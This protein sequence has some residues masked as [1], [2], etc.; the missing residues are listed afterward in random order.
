MPHPPG[1]ITYV[2]SGG[3]CFPRA[4]VTKLKVHTNHVNVPSYSDGLITWIHSPPDAVIGYTKLRD[5]FVQWRSW[6][7]TLD[8]VV[9]WWYYQILPDPHE[10]EWGGEISMGWDDTIKHT[11][12]VVATAAA[13]TDYYFDLPPAPPSYWTV[14]V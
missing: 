10:Y 8:F 2:P 1:V 3:F 7:K 13:D 6:P 4:Y 9:E 14:P 5:N 12:L 11:C